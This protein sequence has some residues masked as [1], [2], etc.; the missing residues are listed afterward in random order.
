MTNTLVYCSLFVNDDT[1]KKA[2][3]LRSSETFFFSLVVIKL[4]CKKFQLQ[5]LQ[6]IVNSFEE[7][8]NI[9]V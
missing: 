2:L 3:Q 5:T 8:E 9:Q 6:L 1:N 4:G 7:S